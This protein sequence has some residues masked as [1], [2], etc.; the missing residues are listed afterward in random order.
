MCLTRPTIGFRRAAGAAQ[1]LQQ[2]ARLCAFPLRRPAAKPRRLVMVGGAVPRPAATSPLWPLLAVN[3]WPHLGRKL[4]PGRAKGRTLIYSRLVRR[5]HSPR[6]QGE[7]RR[8][9][10]RSPAVP[11]AGTNVVRKVQPRRVRLPSS[12][13]QRRGRMQR[14]L[15]RP[16]L[17]PEHSTACAD[18]P[19]R[20][21]QIAP[22]A[23]Q[24]V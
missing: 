9:T 24:Q 17:C 19:H 6:K 10:S 7:A 18:P 2:Q 16:L 21:R 1:N 11:G 14:V 4:T 12:E 20:P 3:H 13:R 22:N 5:L 15:A 8:R 23:N